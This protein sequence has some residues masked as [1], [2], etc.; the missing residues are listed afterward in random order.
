[1]KKIKAIAIFLTLSQLAFSQNLF[2]DDPSVLQQLES[3]GFH[4]SELALSM[5]LQ[6]SVKT[7]SAITPS[8]TNS[9]V[10]K[11]ERRPTQS[12]TLPTNL[13]TNLSAAELFAQSEA[14]RSIVK[15]LESDLAQ[16]L[17]QDPSLSTSMNSGHRLFD[18][19]WL[20]SSLAFFELVGIVNRA[21]RSYADGKYCG[22]IRYIYRLAYR[23]KDPEPIYSRL[24]LTFN[25]VYWQE[26]NPHCQKAH[27]RWSEFYQSLMTGQKIT[28]L[29]P[30]TSGGLKAVEVNLQVVRWPSTVRPDMGGYAEYLLRV[31]QRR[32]NIFG[33]AGL[34][35][36]PDVDRIKKNPILKK[37]LLDWLL[38]ASQLKALDEGTLLI[39]DQ[40]LSN[41]GISVALNGVHR[42]AN[43]PFHALFEE[44][45]FKGIDYQSYQQIKSSKGLLK[46]LNDLSCVGCHQGR[47]VA[48]FHFL[49]KDRQE[50]DAVNAIQISASPHFLTD[51][52]RRNEFFAQAKLGQ[53][54][55]AARPFSVRPQGDAGL[56]G[57][58]CGLGDP[59]FKNWTCATGYECVDFLND[60]NLSPTG[61]CMPVQARAGSLCL[62]G[63]I[64]HDLNSHKD[65][66]QLKAEKACGSSQHCEKVR[67]GFPGGLCSGGCENLKAGEVCGS[68][69]ILQGFNDCLFQRKHSFSHCLKTNV[70]PGSLQA[71]SETE[72][73]RDDY[74]C[75]RTSEGKGGCIPPYFLFQLRVDGHPKPIS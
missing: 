20:K 62:P 36:T 74:I 53:A 11:P 4:F 13:A 32:G 73:C 16:L 3:Q 34:E 72:F 38:E 70:R 64:K 40:Y 8:V 18:Q 5:A 68:I 51:Q 17:V 30:L 23:T 28:E 35:N 47:T 65:R 39:P 60:Q 37:Q 44:S 31:F 2:F 1:M 19:R 22:E 21:D 29:K 46:R 52:K 49:G 48:G 24:P 12:S 56:M 61:V 9:S 14:Y 55:S 43:A 10:T 66:V 69:A 33:H 15:E 63:V 71:C 59:S 57:S 27:L 50:T 26:K 7:P 67:V 25:V 75:A 41:R 42:K 58:H 54:G 45:D 6:S